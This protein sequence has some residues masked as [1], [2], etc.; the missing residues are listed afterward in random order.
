MRN[1]KAETCVGPR[2]NLHLGLTLNVLRPKI[3]AKFT[4]FPLHLF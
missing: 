3:P 4:T 2:M 1:L